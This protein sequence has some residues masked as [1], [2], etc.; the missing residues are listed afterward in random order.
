[1]VNIVRVYFFGF[2]LLA[3]LCY[4]GVLFCLKLQACTYIRTYMRTYVPTHGRLG[5]R[6]FKGIV[7][8]TSPVQQTA[9]F[10]AL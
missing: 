8:W 5:D 4:W 9:T 3:L 6:N 1:M 7:F 2:V 10:F